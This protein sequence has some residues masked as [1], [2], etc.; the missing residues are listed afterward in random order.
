MCVP[1]HDGEF[2]Q[3]FVGH[4]GRISRI[5]KSAVATMA[6]LTIQSTQEIYHI[7]HPIRLCTDSRIELCG[8]GDLF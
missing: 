2:R 5:G 6:S 4:E 3:E 8:T 1:L 7:L